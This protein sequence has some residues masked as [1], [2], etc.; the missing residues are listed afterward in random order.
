MT[1]TMGTPTV[2]SIAEHD[3]VALDATASIGEAARTMAQR[4]IGSV[5]IRE[6]GELVGLVTERDLLMTVLVRGADATQ[7]VREAMRPEV[8][9]VGADASEV[10]CAALMRDHATRHL[11]VE[12]RGRVVG[13]VSMRDLIN[14]MLHEKQFLID[15]LGTYIN[16]HGS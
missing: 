12:E 13:V 7:P 6:R 8:P 15:Q 4:K 10:A 3:V 1:H 5:A 14:A 9:K 16:G 2:A 11:L